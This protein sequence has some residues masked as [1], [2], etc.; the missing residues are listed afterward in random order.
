[1]FIQARSAA[2]AHIT[3]NQSDSAWQYHI[4]SVLEELS[5]TQQLTE[6]IIPVVFVILLLD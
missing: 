5:D 4:K 3:T 6:G 1:M 2:N